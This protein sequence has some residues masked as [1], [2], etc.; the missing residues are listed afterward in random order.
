MAA[1]GGGPSGS[2]PHRL[3][4]IAQPNP[5]E[6]FD[7]VSEARRNSMK[8]N[9]CSTSTIK[10]QRLADSAKTTP[11]ALAERELEM[12]AAAGSKRGIAASQ[13]RERR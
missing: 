7:H 2:D 9:D 8:T 4:S 6:A 13:G 11:V 12:V 3:C 1:S 5:V 10:T